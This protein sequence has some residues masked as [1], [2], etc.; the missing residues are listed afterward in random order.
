ML[1]DI[2][3][4]KIVLF[5]GL[6]MD[7]GTLIY[8]ITFTVRDMV[9]K[10]A[11]IKAA[12]IVI[13]LA[14]VINLFMAGY[15]WLIGRMPADPSAMQGDFASVLSPV[16]RIVSASILAELFSELLDT[17]AYHLW[18]TRVTKRYQWLRVLISNSVSIPLDSMLFSWVAFGGVLPVPVVWSIVLSNMLVKGAVTLIGLPAIYLVKEN[19]ENLSQ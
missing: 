16:W 4:L 18:V 2:G 13:V 9:H 3:S 17:Q 5:L 6:S 10:V 8:P 7:A 15:F 11:G 12:R 14:G 19:P 1:A